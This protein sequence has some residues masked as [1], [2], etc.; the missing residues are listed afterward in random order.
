[1]AAYKTFAGSYRFLNR[2]HKPAATLTRNDAFICLTTHCGSIQ[3]FVLVAVRK[4]GE[5]NGK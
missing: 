5:L 3:Y 4:R 1:V 2:P